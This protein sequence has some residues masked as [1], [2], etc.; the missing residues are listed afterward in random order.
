M[1]HVISVLPRCIDPF[2]SHTL[3]ECG[4][5]EH[6]DEV[7]LLLC[8][9]LLAIQRSKC[10]DLGVAERLAMLLNGLPVLRAATSPDQV[11]N[12]SVPIFKGM[13]M[14]GIVHPPLELS[15]LLVQIASYDESSDDEDDD[16]LNAFGRGSPPSRYHGG[17]A[18]RFVST[19]ANN[20]WTSLIASAY[21][22]RTHHTHVHG[23]AVNGLK[24]EWATS[25]N[26]RILLQALVCRASN[27][28]PKA[29]PSREGAH[30]CVR[31]C[32]ADAGSVLAW[33]H[34]L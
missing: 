3:V 9:A 8:P 29:A 11:T 5:L 2:P 21:L 14:P 16:K 22:R 30:M 25:R 20:G 6:D 28:T 34:G 7:R 27:A 32:D 1:A 13:Y 19:N 26:V 31:C 33:V 12:S 10:A 4:K 23:L 15:R 18:L 17:G 24:T